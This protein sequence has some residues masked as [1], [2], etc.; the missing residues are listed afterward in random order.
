MVTKKQILAQ[1]QELTDLIKSEE[2]KR[3][4]QDSDE[5]NRI[6]ALLPNIKFKVKDTTFFKEDN[7]LQIRYEL[8]VVRL[9]LDESGNPNKNEFFYSTNVLEMI[10]LEDMKK[11]QDYLER[12]K[13]DIRTKN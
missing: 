3:L 5:L 4:K 1:L 6:K 12:I 10:S 13:N 9:Q 2:F 11:I 8:P 7:V